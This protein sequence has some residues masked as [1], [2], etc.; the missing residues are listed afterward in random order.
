MGKTGED[1][2][3]EI[4]QKAVEQGIKAGY[5]VAKKESKHKF[6]AYRAT[7]ER[8]YSLPV[9][10]GKVE[11]D[12]ERLQELKQDPHLPRRSKD[13]CRFKRAGVRLTDEEIVDALKQDLQAKIAG[14]E[15][16][17]QT[18]QEALE[19]VKGDPQYR[20][21]AGRYFDNIS[22]GEIARELKCD[23][24]TVWRNRKRLVKRVAVRLY[25][26]EAVQKQ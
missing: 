12:R 20:T 4:I 2:L 25:G 1:I 26:V 9:L 22:D 21:L 17:I 7:E 5:Q 19:I 13:I 3:Q 11:K 24:S 16:E 14:D 23:E 15:F 10:I 8:L 18:V 6:N